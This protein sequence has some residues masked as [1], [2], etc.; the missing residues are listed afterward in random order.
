MKFIS[1]YTPNGNYPALARQLETSLK[2]FDLDHD[3][4]LFESFDSWL[5]GV[6][7]KAK[8]IKDKLL[9]YKDTVVWLDI[10]TEIKQFPELLFGDEQLALFNW[11][12]V[13][14]H[15]LQRQ[16]GFP[17]D[18][19]TEQMLNGGA[20]SKWSHT[21]ECIELLDLWIDCLQRPHETDDQMLDVAWNLFDHKN[22]TYRWLPE[23][24]NVIESMF[25][26]RVDPVILH[27][28]KDKAH[29]DSK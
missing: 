17:F 13:D 27:H 3:I 12:A 28:F 29:R 10:D 23:S 4:E 2:K 16:P 15:V 9:K 22:I 24:Y 20:V 25:T 11:F 7:N 8:F 18:P 21:K 26:D 6:D 14:R 19:N 5:S 1:F